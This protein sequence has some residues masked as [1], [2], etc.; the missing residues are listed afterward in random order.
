MKNTMNYSGMT[1][2]LDVGVLMLIRANI[3]S[4]S[5]KSFLEKNEAS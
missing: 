4:T 2:G 5:G 3:C 1:V